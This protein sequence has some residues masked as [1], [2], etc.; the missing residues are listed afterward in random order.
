[1]R[2]VQNPSN[3]PKN[4]EEDSDMSLLRKAPLHIRK[5]ELAFWEQKRSELLQKSLSCSDDKDML[6]DF[7]YAIR[8]VKKSIELDTSKEKSHQ[9]HRT[10]SKDV[11]IHSDSAKAG[12]KVK[13]AS[14]KQKAA[15]RKYKRKRG[16][17]PFSDQV[18]SAYRE[19]ILGL[20]KDLDFLE[21][22]AP[23]I[24]P[25]N[26]WGG[27]SD[28]QL[29]SLFFRNRIVL[30]IV[31]WLRLQDLKSS[32]SGFDQ[33]RKQDYHTLLVLLLQ[34]S[35]AQEYEKRRETIEKLDGLVT[36]D[37]VIR[38]DD[39]SLTSLLKRAT[40]GIKYHPEYSTKFSD[41]RKNVKDEID[42]MAFEL[43]WDRLIEKFQDTENI[44]EALILATIDG[45]HNRILDNARKSVKGRLD[46]IEKNLGKYPKESI[47][48]R[49]LVE[50]AT[51]DKID[52]E[53]E[54]LPDTSPLHELITF[55]EELIQSAGLDSDDRVLIEL[56][57]EKNTQKE[58]AKH[59]GISQP[60]VSQKIAK[61]R[62]KVELILNK[63]K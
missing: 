5:E 60:A 8:L 52:T 57:L 4:N 39:E 12:A 22:C 59:F 31:A 53:R 44:R 42:S 29:V 23:Q 27:F 13:S 37:Y 48:S 40:E 18:P 17:K 9:K 20:E 56:L 1:M 28:E 14:P 63:H 10:G 16:M 36:M 38:G 62:S 51:G 55:S 43:L 11:S 35:L 3:H 54:D 46:T 32:A 7:D 24:L 50:K 58:I 6:A 61:L 26:L 21:Y 47:G 25:P 2:P 33:S 45:T 30:R 41:D 34:T 19:F 15:V 49:I